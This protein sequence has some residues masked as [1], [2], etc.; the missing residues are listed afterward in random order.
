MV[1]FTHAVLMEIEVLGAFAGAGSRPVNH[2]FVII[3]NRDGFTGISDSKVDGAVLDVKEFDDAG[4][5]GENKARKRSKFKHF[6]GGTVVNG[7]TKLAAPASVAE[8]SEVEAVCGS[9]GRGGIRICLLIMMARKM[10]RYLGSG[11]GTGVVGD[12]K[13]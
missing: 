4:V 1:C 5:G 11:V 9:R 6:E 2:G 10:I 13:F 7:N 12:A 3:V 8:G